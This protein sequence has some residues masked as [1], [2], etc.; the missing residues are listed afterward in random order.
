MT[1]SPYDDRLMGPAYASS[2]SYYSDS[3]RDSPFRR[4]S[5]LYPFR[6]SAISRM[7]DPHF[8][9]NRNLKWNIDWAVAYLVDHLEKTKSEAAE[10]LR[11]IRIK[12]ATLLSDGLGPKDIVY[13]IFNC[14][15]ATLFA[16]HLKDAVYL[17]TAPLSPSLS[18][19]TYNA[20]WGPEPDVSRIS[21]VLNADI[22]EY[23]RARDVVALLIHQMIHAYFLV[24][25]GPQ[26]ENEVDYGR[27]A[28]G[29]H[30]GKILTTIKEIS[31]T[32]GKELI[33]LVFGHRFPIDDLYPRHRRSDIEGET[34]WYC[35]HCHAS[36][37]PIPPRDINKW[38]NKTISPLLSPT[39]S[40]PAL[41]SA[42]VQIYNARAH[43]L[44]T[45]P[46]ARLPASTETIEVLYND[47]ATLLDRE[48]VKENVHT[49]RRA[50]TSSR[51]LKL[52]K[53]D[54]DQVTFTL[55]LEF[56]HMG[57]Y[58]ASPSHCYSG[59]RGAL[60]LA[61]TAGHQQREEDA[62][63]LADIRFVKFATAMRFEEC[64]DYGTKR[65][66]AYGAVDEDPIAVLSEIFGGRE[67]CTKLRNWVGRF[68]RASSLSAEISNPFTASQ[69][70]QTNLA[71]LESST[72]PWRARFLDAIDSSGGLENE[73]RKARE[74]FLKSGG[75][76]SSST[77]TLGGLNQLR[78]TGGPTMGQNLLT[79]GSSF[80][81][82]NQG[83]IAPIQYHQHQLLLGALATPS[84]LTNL[85]T[86]LAN[87]LTS[88]SSPHTP[89][90]TNTLP[91][92][93]FELE[94][95]KMLERHKVRELER[96]RG[97]L[98]KLE[99]E[100][101]RVKEMA[102]QLQIA[103]ALEEDSEDYD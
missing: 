80:P 102:A 22:L 37:P 58:R 74:D 64:G 85:L 97:K 51:F 14:L 23:A 59:G 16:G 2:Q 6:H 13:K 61:P 69:F 60:V 48:K 35:T 94:Q 96:E 65:L 54:V 12:A 53:E 63:I 10:A 91:A 21:I 24:A 39:L 47:T 30:F 98:R 11:N 70:G 100:K 36:T 34:K 52:D 31:A 99:R 46:R 50:L 72:G 20:N 78:L 3:D 28:H 67:P 76:E 73:V 42:T 57:M 32:H 33:S 75:W 83:L 1:Y 17:S 9:C 41:R 40:L 43:E 92:S 87:L 82:T 15:D 90:T 19:A 81:F 29:K 49:A 101:E 77:L 88:P 45:R 93:A 71:K 55:F 56:A 44:E 18:G 27:L 25:C 38:Y 26:K 62:C 68:L 8:K 66:D 4:P 86:P 5:S 89:L 95:L 103:N 7:R 79:S 84:S